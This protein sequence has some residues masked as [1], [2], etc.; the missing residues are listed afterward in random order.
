MDIPRGKEVARRRFLIRVALSAVALFGAAGMTYG[1]RQLKPAAPTVEFSTVWPDTVKRG[2]MLRQVRGLGTLVPEQ[3]LFI[4]AQSDGRIERIHLR[5]G[6]AVKPDTVILELSNPELKVAAVTAQYDLKVAEAGLVDVSVN[7]QSLAFDKE[8]AAARVRA[9]YTE[10]KLRAERDEKLQKEGLI[11]Q[12]DVSISSSKARELGV[13]NGLEEKRLRI[14]DNSAKAQI[15]SQ[16]VKIEQL[17]ALYELKQQQIEQLKVR[18]GITGVLLQL[19]ADA[20]SGGQPTTRL[21]VGQRVTAGSVLAK[22]AQPEKLKAELKITETEAKDIALGQAASIDTR[23][24]VNAGKV[25]RIDPAAV[26]GTVTVDVALLGGLPAG[27][28]PDL[29]VDGTVELERLNDVVYVGRPTSGQPNSTITLFR[30]DADRRNANRVRIKLGRASVSVIEVTEGLR[31][32]DQ[33]ILS[34]M[35]AW[36]SHD[37]I[38]LN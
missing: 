17:R 12:L 4:P 21:E 31:P 29:S 32:G 24:G 22:I 36:D 37:R 35:S 2:P 25:T 5:A 10:A 33:V 16:K 27:A 3:I 8:S 38:R 28:R 9:D 30:I 18:A 13:Q 19:G 1:V 14:I 34:D 7:V 23:N 15:E 6:Q 11:S 20:P 26:N